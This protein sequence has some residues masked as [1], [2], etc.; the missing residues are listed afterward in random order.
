VPRYP[1]GSPDQFVLVVDDHDDS[2][3][4]MR[5]LLDLHGFQVLTAPNGL[6]AVAWLDNAT[7]LPSLIVLDLAMPVMDGRRFLV[8]RQHRSDWRQIPLIVV[9]GL[10][11]AA[12]QLRGLDVAAFH[13]KP[14][15]SARLLAQIASALGRPL[16]SQGASAAGGA[17]SA[18]AGD[19]AA[20]TAVHAG[21][22]SDAVRDEVLPEPPDATSIPDPNAGT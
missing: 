12:E 13:T 15:R 5:R 17:G 6:E 4:M 2:R 8:R 18:A 14:V 10:Q 11:D 7:I 9:S 3:A 21:A 19:V 20:Q 22:A 16:P 1:L